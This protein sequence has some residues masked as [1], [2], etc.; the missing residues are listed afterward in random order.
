MEQ[1]FTFP[2]MN[3]D[4]YYL[5]YIP[6]IN[7]PGDGMILEVAAIHVRGEE[8][9]DH[10]AE[11]ANPGRI[12][13]T[14]QKKTGVDEEHVA[15]RCDPRKALKRV[16][17][18][19][20]DG[21]VVVHDAPTFL[22]F[23]EESH[24]HPPGKVVDCL[25]LARI[26]LPTLSDFSLE[27]LGDELQVD[28]PE[29]YRALDLARL[30]SKLWNGLT[31]R[32]LRLPE[33]VLKVLFQ[34]AEY[35][36]DPLADVL[37]ELANRKAGFDLSGSD[38]MDLGGIFPDMRELF[39]RAQ[40]YGLSEPAAVVLDT[41][42]I[43]KMF[44][45]DG[46]IGRNLSGYEPRQ[47]QV[48]MV[49]EV[50]RAFNGPHHLMFE[51]GTG[52]G[53]SMAYLL[54]AIAWACQNK[55]KVIVSTNTKN[56]QGQL[57]YKDLPFLERLFEDRFKPALLK[58]RQ[59]YLCLRRLLHVIDH[60][61]SELADEREAVAMMPLVSWAATTEDGDLSGCRGLLH[62]NAAYSLVP[63]VTASGDECAGKACSVRNSCFVRRARSLAQLADLIVVNHALLL[64]DVALDQPHLPLSNCVIFD[65][66]HNVEEV[67]TEALAVTA[68]TLGFY[69]VTRRLWRKRKDG[70]G[71]GMVAT[72]LGI[73][74]RQLPENGAVARDTVRDVA[75]G[76]IESVDDVV[77]GT[78]EFF[79]LLAEPFESV[80][81]YEDKIMLDECRPAITMDSGVGESAVE[82]DKKVRKLMERIEDL[83]ES[84]EINS[85]HV[86]EAEELATDL[87]GQQSRL[88]E[89]MEAVLFILERSGEDY[90]YWLERRSQRNRY[91][92]SMHAAPLEIGRFMRDFFFEDRRTVILTS[93]TMRVS[94][95]FDY[96]KERLGADYLRDD[97][98][99]CGGV[100]S[101]FDYERQSMVCVPTFL[102][103]AGGRRDRAYDEEL[104][105]F[106]ID[107]IRATEGRALVLFT[108]YSLLNAV[109]E[110]IKR[111]L[112]SVGLPVL[113]QGK[114]GSREALTTLFRENQGSVLL[115]TQ[116]F[117]EGVDILGETLSCLVLTKLPFHVFTDPLVQ[118]RIQ[119]LRSHGMDPFRHY[120]LPEATISFR[121]G[122]GRLIRHRNDKG[123]VVVTDK[124]IVTKSYG[125]SFLQDIP[126]RHRVY[127]YREP[128]LQDI[129]R[130][131][132]D[133]GM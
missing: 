39:S 120:T 26:A 106:L 107:L 70:S 13:L 84:L 47:E 31:E 63:K 77:N 27:A 62:D 56:L 73:V 83:A 90:V 79:E 93:A 125:R 74:R 111:P 65:E 92:Y 6:T 67:A 22:G 51:A 32:L 59:N 57:F 131:F 60:F 42:K 10:V 81:A 127:K 102:P 28:P 25:E 128:L 50:C 71:T 34:F 18:F 118:G 8:E 54:P 119:Y 43:C 11:L 20:D 103:D 1:Y 105:S 49:R 55:D 48:E 12:P 96:I 44:E 23:L 15:G 64:S 17:D 124:R 38:G 101:P 19:V 109:Y 78:R 117:W 9:V 7:V 35:A 41:G 45:P 114:D 76:V 88:K 113:G 61:R 98:L 121:Q 72:I 52:T 99:V 129:R 130:F 2:V 104:S 116:S 29:M 123:V 40:K 95:R 16:L 58:G 53:K 87:R 132:R 68:D 126:T 37:A 21:T 133:N 112:E 24:I 75:Q 115:G 82:L 91:Y 4:R 97:Q 5:S 80:P 14:L 33:Q 85:S 36:E 46:A 3:N 86:E 100:G 69:R 122:F 66:A 89:A 110:R 108:S 94:R 30:T